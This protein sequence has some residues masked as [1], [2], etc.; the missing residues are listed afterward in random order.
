MS[1]F[2]QLWLTCSDKKEANKIANTL[3]VKQLIACAKQVEVKSDF[4]WQD[5][6]EYEEEVLLLMDSRLG[7]FDEI[8]QE[9]S[10]LHSYE[11]FVLQATSIKKISKEAEEWLNNEAKN[12]KA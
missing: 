5:K 10:K 6:I 1:D 2:C 3:L 11:T 4:R 12:G 9:V 8:E 7:L